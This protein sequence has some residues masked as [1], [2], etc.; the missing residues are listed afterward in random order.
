[1]YYTKKKIRWNRAD[2]LY[3]GTVK[4]TALYMC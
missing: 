1:M 2:V 4:R 3:E